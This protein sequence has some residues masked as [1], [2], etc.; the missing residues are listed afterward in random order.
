MTPTRSV[1]AVALSLHPAARVESVRDG[2]GRELAFVREHI[3]ELDRG[4]DDRLNDDDLAVFFPGP[5]GP[6]DGPLTLTVAYDREM[7]NYVSG[8][9]WYPSPPSSIDDLHTAELRIKARKRSE[10]RAIGSFVEKTPGEDDTVTWAYAMEQP[11]KMHGFSFADRF[12]EAEIEAEGVPKV[13][14]FSPPVS[15]R[16]KAMVKNVGTDLANSLRFFQWLFDSTLDVDLMQATGI[17]A[18]H[19]QAFEGFLHLGEVTFAQEST[20]SSELFRS[21]EV[22]HQ[23]WGHLVGW[24]TYRDQWLSEAFAEYSAMMFVQSTMEDG[25]DIFGDIVKAYYEL[26]MGER[27]A[28]FNRF[29]RPWMNGVD[30]KQRQRLGPIGHG[31]RASTAE[32]RQG[33]TLQNYYKGPMVLH[34]LRH[35]LQR[36]GQGD[37]L[38][39][40]VLRDFVAEHRGTSATTDD[41]RRVLE[42]RAG[43]N[44]GWF[45]DQWVYGT[46]IPSYTWSYEVAQADGQT[47]LELTVRQEDVPEGFMMSVPVRL[48]LAGGQSGTVRVT[49]QQPEETFR[50]PVPAA[51]KKVIFNPDHAVLARVSKR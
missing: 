9:S 46:A 39:I 23:W 5:V 36:P 43:G 15:S 44:W 18:G 11:T 51:P 20:S 29:V 7:L 19:G 17:A 10:V 50:L 16:S 22:A 13:V 40:Q 31:F 26:L 28:N 48:E 41:F 33:Y 4:L 38:F 1:G 45:F 32:M 14:S 47:V 25:D 34:M 3:G 21:H 35:L 42:K 12:V 6:E 30:S 2:D 37:T 49:V 24:Q 27:I 8:R